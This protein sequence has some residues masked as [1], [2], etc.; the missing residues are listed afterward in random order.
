HREHRDT[1]EGKAERDAYLGR[2]MPD[3]ERDC[4]PGGAPGQYADREQ[5]PV[6]EPMHSPYSA[7]SPIGRGTSPS[8][9]RRQWRPVV[10]VGS[11][12]IARFPPAALAISRACA[13][14][15]MQSSRRMSGSS[16]ATPNEA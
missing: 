16:S 7:G 10:A 11:Q 4:V 5:L 12:L 13:A 3:L 1:R 15:S 8:S 2:G 9:R 14:W 6:L